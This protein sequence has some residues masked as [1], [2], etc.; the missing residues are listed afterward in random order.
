MR[1][2]PIFAVFV[3]ALFLASC[4]TTQYVFDPFS[5]M[6]PVPASQPILVF[7]K[8]ADLP[9]NAEE[10]GYIN[11]RME[12]NTTEECS[13]GGALDLLKQTSRKL[14]ANIV[15]ITSVKQP[16][17]D[18]CYHVNTLLYRTKVQEVASN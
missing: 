4:T 15:L 17:Q 1:L 14:G 3:F 12:R 8:A 5:M 18:S 10:A 13:Y 11:I 16:T 7:E 9:A 6:E 2:L